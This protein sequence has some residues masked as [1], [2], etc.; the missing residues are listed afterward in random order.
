MF[1][2]GVVISS[3]GARLALPEQGRLGSPVGGE[4]VGR[5]GEWLP[6]RASSVAYRWDTGRGYVTGTVLDSE[7]GRPEGTLRGSAHRYV[8]SARGRGGGCLSPRFG[9]PFHFDVTP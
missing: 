6:S 8:I 3:G 1:G 2:M 7:Y 4:S 9:C 5:G